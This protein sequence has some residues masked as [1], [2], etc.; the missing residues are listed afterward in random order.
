M[1]FLYRYH[2]YYPVQILSYNPLQELVTVSIDGSG[3]VVTV[4]LADLAANGDAPE[5]NDA[6]RALLTTHDNTPPD[7]PLDPGKEPPL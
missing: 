1:I 3:T 6:L 4:P 2:N 5:V 7:A